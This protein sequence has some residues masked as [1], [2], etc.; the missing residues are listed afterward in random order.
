[1]NKILFPKRSATIIQLNAP[2]SL[3]NR[4]STISRNR[5]LE[6]SQF[7][8]DLSFLKLSVAID[9]SKGDNR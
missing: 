5:V 3:G 2:T 4:L 7:S 6:K 1:M 9:P 8:A